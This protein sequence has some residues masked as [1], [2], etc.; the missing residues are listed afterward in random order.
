M[1]GTKKIKFR[2]KWYSQQKVLFTTN[3]NFPQDLNLFK[4]VEK[5]KLSK[6][7]WVSYSISNLLRKTN[8][9]SISEFHSEIVNFWLNRNI[10]SKFPRK[11]FKTTGKHSLAICGL[12]FE[13]KNRFCLYLSSFTA[14]K[15]KGCLQQILIF[16]WIC[17][18]SNL[19][20][21]KKFLIISELLSEI[22]FYW[23]KKEFFSEIPPKMLQNNRKV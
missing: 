5:N 23:I 4:L 7:F 2:E 18:F 1:T 3:P 10:F 21:K 14:L 8:F 12:F 6:Y 17:S 15:K 20:R 11:R 16:L 9:L 19:F 13:V 22:F